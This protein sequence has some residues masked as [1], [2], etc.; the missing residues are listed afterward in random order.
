MGR[1]ITDFFRLGKLKPQLVTETAFL[2]LVLMFE[3]LNLY[4][5]VT[6]SLKKYIAFL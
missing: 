6:G 4:L 5:Q 1:R 3:A 2:F